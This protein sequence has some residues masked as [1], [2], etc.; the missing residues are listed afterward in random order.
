MITKIT[1]GTTNEGK[2]TEAR[3]LLDLKVEGVSFPVFEIQD[4]DPIKVALKK[5][6]DYFNLAKKPVLVEDISLDFVAL[7]G[8]PGVYINDFSAKLGN[9]GLIELLN[10]KDDKSAIARVVYAYAEGEGEI[11]TFAGEISGSI[12]STPVGENGFGWDPIFMPSGSDK[13]FAQMDLTE[14]NRYSMRRI[15]LEKFKKYINTK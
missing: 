12:V 5:A 13:T 1:L 7:N 3:S 14:K 4:L 2:L 11:I 15:A 9:S 8:L 10:D 6:E